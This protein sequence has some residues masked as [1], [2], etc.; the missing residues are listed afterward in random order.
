VDSTSTADELLAVARAN[1]DALVLPRISDHRSL[2]DTYSAQLGRHIALLTYEGGQSITARAPD[3]GLDLA[4]T[5]ECQSK[6]AMFD[7]YRALIEGAQARGVELFV[8]Y[9]F[10]GGRS[11]ADTFSVLEYLDEPMATAVKYRALIQGWENRG[12]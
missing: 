11:G 6:P 3:G 4:A 2:A 1:I 7:A 8:G 10:V 9:D 5:L 12:Q